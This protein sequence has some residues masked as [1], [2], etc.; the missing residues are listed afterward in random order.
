M[1]EGRSEFVMRA[2]V[3][4]VVFTGLLIL[5]SSSS[6]WAAQLDAR[7]VPDEPSAD[8]KITYQRNIWIGYNE[9][10]QLADELRQKSWDVTLNADSS[11]P[12]VQDL[13]Q[14]INQN[15]AND[16]SNARITD[17]IVEYKASLIGRGLNTSI[18]YKI[19][20]YPTLSNYNIYTYIVTKNTY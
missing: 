10:G 1:R 7:L 19:I 9:G 20:L 18:D 11:N 5:G 14:K 15:I 13:I 12:G 16:G 4:T 2:L 8:I 6:V 17:M 3:L